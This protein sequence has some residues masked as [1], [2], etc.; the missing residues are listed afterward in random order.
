MLQ[1]LPELNRNQWDIVLEP[2]VFSDL[3]RLDV[4]Y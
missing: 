1:N 3:F 2:K 4:Q